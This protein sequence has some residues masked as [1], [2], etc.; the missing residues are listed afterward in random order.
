M[1]LLVHPFAHHVN[2]VVIHHDANAQKKGKHEFVFLKQAAAYIAVQAEG[3]KFI[4]VGDSFF[5]CVCM[6]QK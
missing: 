1:T 6:K 3:E 5:H 4:D 2:F